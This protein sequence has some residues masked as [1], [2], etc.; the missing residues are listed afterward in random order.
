MLYQ[1]RIF[2]NNWSESTSWTSVLTA[3]RRSKPQMEPAI[4]YQLDHLNWSNEDYR[5]W[6]RQFRLLSVCLTDELANHSNRTLIA[7]SAYWKL[8]ACHLRKMLSFDSGTPPP[9]R[10]WR[11]PTDYGSPP[12]VSFPIDLERVNVRL[13]NTTPNLNGDESRD[14]GTLMGLSSTKSVDESAMRVKECKQQACHL[15]WRF[16][17]LT[18]WTADECREEIDD[19]EYWRAEALH[20]R[21]FI[22]CFIHCSNLPYDLRADITAL[23]YWTTEFEHYLRRL[24][25]HSSRS[26]SSNAH[27]A[28]A[29]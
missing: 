3:Q 7:E 1:R 19:Y 6:K 26:T 22:H 29:K 13:Q 21:S 5:Y 15:G 18:G 11:F 2:V 9:K 14:E 20:Y 28:C 27:Q 4:L 10:P 8:E 17:V 23:C 16:S 12:P 25:S 24:Q